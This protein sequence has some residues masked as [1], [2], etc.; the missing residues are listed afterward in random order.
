MIKSKVFEQQQKLIDRKA[1]ELSDKM[2]END[3]TITEEMVN[4]P[5]NKMRKII[6][7]MGFKKTEVDKI[8]ESVRK[9]IVGKEMKKRD[10]FH[11]LMEVS[12]TNAI[13]KR[14]EEIQR[15]K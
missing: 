10:N 5:L 14:L 2:S 11:K 1:K 15:G 13:T 4:L 7:Y 6:K 9:D 8:I 12:F 3:Y